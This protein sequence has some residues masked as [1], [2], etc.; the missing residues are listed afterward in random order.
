MTSQNTL[1]RFSPSHDTLATRG[2][3]GVVVPATNT[4]V[5]PEMELM[6]PPGVT[7]HVTRMVLPPRPYDDQE[8]YKKALETEKGNLEIALETLLV[9]E[10]HVVAHGH[11]IH[12]FRGDAHLAIEEERRIEELCGVPFIT[13]SRA[14]LAGLEAIGNPKKIA[15]LTP[16]WPPADEMIANFFQK[17]GYEVTNTYGMKSTGPTAVAQFSENDIM[18]SFEKVNDSASAALIHV[19]TNLPVS[20]LT[21]KIEE[22]FGKPLIGVN[23]ATYWL[24]LRKIG[25]K[26]PILGMGILGGL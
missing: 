16:Y 15:I 11:S 24:A 13:P 12:S 26:D 20:S 4:V 5:Q 25:I 1:V 17:S 22:R 14:V 23:V 7:N 10:P 18:A 21:A 6:R 2:K 8:A 19:G 9:C 3:I